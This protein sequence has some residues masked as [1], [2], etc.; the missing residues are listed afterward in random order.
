MATTQGTNNT[1]PNTNTNNPVVSSTTTT[2]TTTT[3]TPSNIKTVSVT[4]KH[5]LI[6]YINVTLGT[7]KKLIEGDNTTVISYT[8]NIQGETINF[9]ILSDHN[10]CISG[11]VND[12]KK[13]D[14]SISVNNTI[15]DK[16]YNII[17]SALT[18]TPNV[19]TPSTLSS[20]SIDYNL[21]EDV[22]CNFGDKKFNASGA[23]YIKLDTYSKPLLTCYS[24]SLFYINNMSYNGYYSYLFNTGSSNYITLTSCFSDVNKPILPPKQENKFTNIYTLYNNSNYSN[25]N[26]LVNIKNTEKVNS[27]LHSFNVVKVTKLNITNDVNNKINANSPNGKLCNLECKFYYNNS[28]TSISTYKHLKWELID[29]SQAIS[30]KPNSENNLICELYKSGTILKNTSIKIKVTDLIT[31]LVTYNTINVI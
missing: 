26:I 12:V 3:T 13:Y 17:S 19:T 18:T 22:V 29:S 10:I 5:N 1:T 28:L 21:N 25:T 7:T 6:S 31:K 23:G 11:I 15:N 9:N 8:G 20:L 16:N 14:R 4:I 27:K 30:L 24:R 2:T